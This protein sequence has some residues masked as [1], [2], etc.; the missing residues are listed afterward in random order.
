M[1][2]HSTSHRGIK[3]PGNKPL[4][5]PKVTD[6]SGGYRRCLIFCLG[7]QLAS[8]S[9]EVVGEPP[10]N[11]KNL[12]K[13]NQHFSLS[14]L[15]PVAFSGSGNVEIKSFSGNIL[16]NSPPH[17]NSLPGRFNVRVWVFSSP[18]FTAL[19]Q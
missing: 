15:E 17:H 2:N 8:T 3:Q 9:R 1:G 6:R 11:L 19:L 7:T 5:T 4:L 14:L 16:S 18:V 13:T 12:Q 10:K